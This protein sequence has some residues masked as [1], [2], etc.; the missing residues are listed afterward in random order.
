MVENLTAGLRAGG[1]GP[2]AGGER[3]GGVVGD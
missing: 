3:R 1:P 2:G